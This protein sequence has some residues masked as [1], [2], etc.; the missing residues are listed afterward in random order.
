MLA[1]VVGQGVEQRAV[2]RRVGGAQV[3]HRLD[4]PA[5][6]QVGPDA[7][8]DHPGEVRVV[9]GGHPVGQRLA[10]VGVGSSLDRGRAEQR[11]RRQDLAGERMLHLAR[12]RREDD[13]LAARD[14]RRE[15]RPLAADAGEVGGEL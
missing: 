13:L 8:D 12:L 4:Q 3:V 5:A 9:G 6:H 7:I 1:E 2:A 14:R 10:R 15:A 11:P